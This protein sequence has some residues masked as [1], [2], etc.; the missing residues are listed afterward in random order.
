MSN[1]IVIGICSVAAAA[2][3]GAGGFLAASS[4]SDSPGQTRDDTLTMSDSS[5]LD[6][7]VAEADADGDAAAPEQT[8]APNDRRQRPGRHPLRARR[9][10][11][12]L[13][14][15]ATVRT[16]EQGFK[17]VAWQRGQVTS[18]SGGTLTVRSADGVS[19]QWTTNKD[20]KVRKKGDKA[21]VSQLAANDW[22]FVIGTVEGSTRTARAAVVPKRVPKNAPAPTPTS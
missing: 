6:T 20:T 19:W 17:Q 2:V 12:G 1:K 3:I 11:R 15:E 14:G 13:H 7:A 21:S 8:A 18:V 9:F 22:V 4:S 16:K 10:F 5:F